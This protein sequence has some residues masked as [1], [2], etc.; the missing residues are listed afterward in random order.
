M[1]LRILL[2][3]ILSLLFSA[4]GF[5]LSADY[6]DM[7]INE[8]AWMGTSNSYNDEWIELYNNTDFPINLNNWTLKAADG[9]PEII[10]SGSIPANGFYLLERTNDDSAPNITAD[11]IYTGALNNDGEHLKLFDVRNNLIDEINCNDNWFAGDKNKNQT[12]EKINPLLSSDSSNWQTSKNPDGTPKATNSLFVKRESESE[13]GEQKSYP[14]NIIFS[15]ILPSPKGPDS[16]N[17]YIEIFNKNDFEVD[18]SGWN[19]KDSVGTVNGFGFPEKTIIKAQSYLIVLRPETKI[20]L[21]NDGDSL[22][23]IQPDGAVA[24]AVNYEKAENGQS[25]N[26]I[27]S[28]WIWSQ[29][30][31][32]GKA[33]IIKT[34][35]DPEEEKIVLK[36]KS[37]EIKENNDSKELAS[38]LRQ[39]PENNNDFPR[40]FLIALTVAVFSAV[41]ILL[42]KKTMQKLIFEKK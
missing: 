24:D 18:L 29:E 15:E 21:N 9:K 11:Q 20:I 16:E 26:L 32:P 12:M 28:E 13:Q 34:P 22:S 7:T 30:T 14:A 38:V 1:K 10:L 31:T 6:L 27:G 35:T 8:I 17:E 2:F 23:L 5:V 25:I 4:Q 19:I 40:L 39:I 36:E 3:I 41:M 42:L 37:S 33:N